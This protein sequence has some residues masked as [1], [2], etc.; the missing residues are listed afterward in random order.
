MSK[1]AKD[2]LTDI[3]RLPA[4]ISLR[5]QNDK[6]AFRWKRWA[7]KTYLR[8]NENTRTG[9]AETR[10]LGNYTEAEVKSDIL[11]SP[12]LTPSEGLSALRY[13]IHRFPV[14]TEMSTQESEVMQLLL[15]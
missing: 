13:I 1:N 3:R 10:D 14:H 2:T 11:D 15:Q 9:N 12:L 8:W 5:K 7:T 4:E 6:R